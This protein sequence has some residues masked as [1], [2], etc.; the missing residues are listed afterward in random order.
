MKKRVKNVIKREGA[1]Y[2]YIEYKVIEIKYEA[3]WYQN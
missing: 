2:N 3:A 1:T